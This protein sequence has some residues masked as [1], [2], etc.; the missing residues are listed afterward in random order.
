MKKIL[1][2]A[3]PVSGGF[4]GLPRL[5]QIK[6]YFSNN[7]I[8]SEIYLTQNKNS[9]IEYCRGRL[10]EFTG[11]VAAG[12]DG[13]IN[14]VSQI[15]KFKTISLGIIPSGTAN[16]LANEFKIPQHDILKCAEIILNGKEKELDCWLANERIFLLMLS[17]GIDSAAVENVNLSLK[18]YSGKFAYFFSFLKEFFKFKLT[19]YQIKIIS[20]KISENKNTN[21]VNKPEIATN[22]FFVSNIEKYAGNFKLNHSKN[23]NDGLIELI[24]FKSA[25]RLKYLKFCYYL[26]SG[27][28]PEQL[29]FIKSVKAGEL[30]I[31]GKIPYPLEFDGE[32]GLKTPVAIK[33]NEH[34]ILLKIPYLN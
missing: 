13:L 31:I 30:E 5:E 2:I 28:N 11:F 3:N 10:D 29:D 1:I 12:G 6:S 25:S 34:K 27:K 23:Y 8:Y 22:Q 24:F 20:D 21:T 7:G 9:A 17:G 4:I 33:L 32:S 15:A 26:F 19:D 18:K 14:E 16:V